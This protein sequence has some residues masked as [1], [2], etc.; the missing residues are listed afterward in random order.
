P[1]VRRVAT[2]P[3]EWLDASAVQRLEQRLG[4]G[5]RRA[6]RRGPR[7]LASV[8]AEWG[9][10]GEPRAVIAAS[11]RP[12]EPWFC[13][14]RPD[15]EG[16]AL[17]A[18]GS[19]SALEDGGRNRFARVAK[20]WRALVTGTA[21]DAPEGPPGSGLVAVGGFAFAP[22]GGGSPS[23]DGFSPASMIVP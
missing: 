16:W 6:R 20:R 23:W 19:T 15:R 21:A 9:R 22:N 5:L 4:D 2:P 8:T 11:P 13:L 18:L 12:G 7:A 3:S 1:V 17:A 10:E 14:G